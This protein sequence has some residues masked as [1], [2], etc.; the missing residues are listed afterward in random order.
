MKEENEGGVV[1]D[2]EEDD[3]VGGG[4]EELRWSRGERGL[5]G[6]GGGRT[7]EEASQK[8]RL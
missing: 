4:G 3:G 2:R 5:G 7:A 8:A 1:G 6:R